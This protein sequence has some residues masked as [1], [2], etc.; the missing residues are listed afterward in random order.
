[1]TGNNKVNAGGTPDGK[2]I[3]RQKAVSK[4]M[5]SH[6]NS[7]YNDITDTRRE[8][9]LASRDASTLYPHSETHTGVAYVREAN[10]IEGHA[11]CT[12]YNWI[13]TRGTLGHRDNCTKED[14]AGDM[15]RHN[16]IFSNDN[17][18]TG[19]L[20]EFTSMEGDKISNREEY[21]IG[22]RNCNSRGRHNKMAY[23]NHMDTNLVFDS[24]LIVNS[25]AD[26][27]NQMYM[28]VDHR[29]TTCSEADINEVACTQGDHIMN[30]CSHNVTSSHPNN[31][32]NNKMYAI[33]S[34]CAVDNYTQLV[35]LTDM[36]RPSDNSSDPPNTSHTRP[37][38]LANLG[39]REDGNQGNNPLQTISTIGFEVTY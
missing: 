22:D 23:T 21:T 12:T 27:H 6:K 16:S 30:N 9:G 3:Y 34:G 17:M 4:D 14:S 25:E 28:E 24:K 35:F 7:L 20:V 18:H 29:M 26:I 8:S 33:S 13:N 32:D 15:G 19:L 1:M 2:V 36:D 5:G 11:H 31:T 10:N 39:G 37:S 38:M